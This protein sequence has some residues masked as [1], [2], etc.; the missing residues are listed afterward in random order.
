M[1]RLAAI[2]VTAILLA[3]CS[4][5]GDSGDAGAPPDS[6]GGDAGAGSGGS[7][8]LDCAAVSRE[9]LNEFGFAVQVLGQV[10]DA[11][12]L[13]SAT[14]GLGY[15]AA[16]MSEI[17]G[18]LRMLEGHPAEG[19]DD[20]ASALDQIADAN[21]LLGAMIASGGDVSDAE[22]A[23]LKAVTGEPG[24]FILLQLPITASLS[25]NCDL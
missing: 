11:S 7:G 16:R 10:D 2:M 24:D 8:D 20:P 4:A 5:G 22:F 9:D 21:E 12:S 15:D 17:I 1:K 6:A 14:E 3:G 19:F 13:E 25:E 23:E 18:V